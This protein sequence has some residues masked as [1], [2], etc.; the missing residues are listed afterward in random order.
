MQTFWLVVGL[1]HARS[2]VKLLHNI[3]DQYGQSQKASKPASLC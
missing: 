3:A 1:L 2:I